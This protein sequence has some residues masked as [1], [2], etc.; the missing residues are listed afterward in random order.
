MHFVCDYFLTF[1][2]DVVTKLGIKLT[3]R[4]LRHTD[5]KMLLQ[6]IFSQWLPIERAVLEMVISIIPKP[7]LMTDDKAERLM[8][9]LSQNFASLPAETQQ[10]KKEFII[11]DKNS[12]TVIVFI[13]KMIPYSKSM[14]PVNKPK[15]L[16]QEE[17]EKRR[18]LARQRHQEKQ[19]EMQEVQDADV[20]V[21]SSDIQ[22]K[23]TVEDE[24]KEDIDDSDDDV[25]AVTESDGGIGKRD[26]SVP[27]L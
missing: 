1:L 14:L 6:T 24:V 16:T 27:V 20:A 9:S 23:L 21:L 12:E 15:P 22:T 25:V 8:C 19:N 26:P 5:A 13:S 17:I 18:A 10:L 2:L 7:G 4:D 3:I 11:S